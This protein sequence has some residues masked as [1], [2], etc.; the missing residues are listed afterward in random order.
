MFSCQ[1]ITRKG[2]YS[3]SSDAYSRINRAIVKIMQAEAKIQLRLY[4][5]T[6]AYWRGKPLFE[7]TIE[8]TG[9]EI[10]VY[11]G[12]NDKIYKFIDKGTS[13]RRA[14][15]SKNF[16][17]KTH[18]RTLPN[19][20]GRGSRVAISKKFNFPG[21]TPREFSKM[22]AEQRYPIFNHNFEGYIT[23]YAIEILKGT[24]GEPPNKYWR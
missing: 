12:T 4:T 15:M 23:S 2:S 19:S 14:L 17:P 24:A 21:I 8:N 13:V 11:V 7:Y 20:R 10:S 9:D 3:G 16:M 6:T 18:P 1:V 5:R 22:I